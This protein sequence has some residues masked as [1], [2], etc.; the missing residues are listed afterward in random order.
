MRAPICSA[1]SAR[2]AA[3]APPSPCSSPTAGSFRRDRRTVA[4]HAAAVLLRDRAGWHTADTLKIPENMTQSEGV[5]G[6]TSVAHEH[7]R[8]YGARQLISRCCADIQ[9]GAIASQ[10][11]IPFR[12]RFFA[13]ASEV[14]LPPESGCS[15][16]S[17]LLH[18]R[19]IWLPTTG[20]LTGFTNPKNTTKP[21]PPQR[22]ET[23]SSGTFVRQTSS[24]ALLPDRRPAR[25]LS[26]GSRP[27]RGPCGRRHHGRH[28]LR[29]R[30][31]PRHHRRQ[32]RHHRHCQ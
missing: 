15:R 26:A 25:R 18:Q 17:A 23:T 3:S 5:S 31:A 8:R 9:H 13:P 14:E 2:R 21:L 19:R 30:S 10:G 1:R 16:R 20:V 6:L 11:D 29:Q 27:D 12:R 28:R 24:G 7:R 4:R 22:V 32:G